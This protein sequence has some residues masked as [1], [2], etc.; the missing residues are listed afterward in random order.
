M[1]PLNIKAPRAVVAKVTAAV[2]ANPEIAVG[3]INQKFA[4]GLMRD[5]GSNGPAVVGIWSWF[6]GT[7]PSLKLASRLGKGEKVLATEVIEDYMSLDTIL[8]VCP[9]YT[10]LNDETIW[11]WSVI[12]GSLKAFFIDTLNYIATGKR[13]FSQKVFDSYM[14]QEAKDYLADEE[15]FTPTN[16]QITP[17]YQ[18]LKGIS[19]QDFMVLWLSRRGGW[20]DVIRSK[21]MIVKFRR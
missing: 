4:S 21:E 10:L 12:D 5:W 13:Q 20:D 7:K 11:E 8:G 17:A 15:N 18:D 2:K 9:F 16:L 19:F 1:N 14:E 3:G 6:G